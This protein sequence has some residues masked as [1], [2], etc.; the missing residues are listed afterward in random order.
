MSFPIFH[1][2]EIK[3]IKVTITFRLNENYDPQARI[4]S[5]QEGVKACQEW[6][7]RHDNK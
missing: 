4:K 6:G 7:K 3:H 2:G 1:Q 5:F